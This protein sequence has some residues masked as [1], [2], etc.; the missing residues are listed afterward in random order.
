MCVLSQFKKTDTSNKKLNES[1]AKIKV[2]IKKLIRNRMSFKQISNVYLIYWL[3]F[4]GFAF[5]CNQMKKKK[6]KLIKI[7]KH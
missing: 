5:I 7:G 1:T 6:V 2:Y 4:L 3:L